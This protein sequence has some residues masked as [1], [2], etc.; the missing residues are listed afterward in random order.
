MKF[1]VTD[2][3]K[4][5]KIIK[6]ELP[7]EDYLSAF[8]KQLNKILPTVK[9]PGFRP[10]KVPKE[11]V[12]KEYKHK[13]SVQA[14][15]ELINSSIDRVIKDSG[16]IPINVPAVKDVVFDEDKPITFD[17]YVDVY[18]AV[19][20]T[21]YKGF[22]FE[23]EV[24]V[25]GDED[26]D[27]VI[28]NMREQHAFFEV[29]PDDAEVKNGD[30]VIIDFEGKKD[31]IPFEGGTAKDF[32][33]DIGSNQFIAGFEDGLIGMKKGETRD[34]NLKFPENYH[35]A[36]LAGQDVVFTVTVKE[37]KSKKLPELNDEFAT[38]ANPEVDS[39]DKLR[40][41][42]KT[43]LI[44]DTEIFNKEAFYDKLLAKLIEENPFDLPDSMIE[45]QSRNLADRAIRNYCR[46]YGI[47]PKKI[48]LDPDKIKDQ[49]RDS[50][51]TQTKGAIILNA[52]AELENIVV[53]DEDVDAKIADFASTL[54]MPV[55]EYKDMVKK[56]GTIN[57]IKNNIL[58]DKIYDFL[59][60]V[61]NVTDK[62]VTLKDLKEREL[63][64]SAQA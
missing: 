63:A 55:E 57:N 48:N 29:A 45:E 24:R 1:N 6:V 60:S 53:T 52:L 3:E 58:V 33:L 18:P 15:E 7:Y 31:G 62:T 11:K 56:N 38:T 4:S 44:N 50:A 21:N 39:F 46:S 10:G 59:C 49:Y 35:A 5:Q 61:N 14:L 51:I 37:I 47:D 34:L 9:M 2:A 26:V 17:V 27:A 32:S 36:D 23:R 64:N 19:K 8:E 30:R 20:I 16:I 28:E 41:S 40:E 42:I 43:D 25:I 12:A 13:I 22:D 54:K